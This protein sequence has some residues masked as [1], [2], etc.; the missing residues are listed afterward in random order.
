MSLNEATGIHQDPPVASNIWSYWNLLDLLRGCKFVRRSRVWHCVAVWV[1]PPNCRHDKI[2]HDLRRISGEA[3]P[4]GIQWHSVASSL[5]GHVTPAVSKE[6]N[7]GFQRLCHGTGIVEMPR[8]CPLKKTNPRFCPCILAGE[9]MRNPSE[10]SSL[11]NDAHLLEDWIGLVSSRL[12]TLQ[13]GFHLQ[14]FAKWEA[15]ERPWGIGKAL[16]IHI[17]Q[18]SA[19]SV[20]LPLVPRV[21]RPNRLSG[22]PTALSSPRP[23]SVAAPEG[24]AVHGCVVPACFP[25]GVAAQSPAA[26]GSNPAPAVHR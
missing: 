5:E 16:N 10:L 6:G 18:C 26:S 24:P 23:H 17:I 21:S 4:S 15:L 12:F 7:S 14:T 11:K 22:N 19:M 2:S 13:A 9:W 3:E 1:L 25:N 20:Q 8:F